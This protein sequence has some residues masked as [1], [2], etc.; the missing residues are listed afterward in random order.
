MEGLTVRSLAAP[1]GD[2]W[3]PIQVNKHRVH[4]D[5]LICFSLQ[6]LYKE[7]LASPADIE[8]GWLDVLLSGS[9][10]G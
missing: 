9:S 5:L 3:L 2:S 8:L 7:F 6:C 1:V 4:K 10:I